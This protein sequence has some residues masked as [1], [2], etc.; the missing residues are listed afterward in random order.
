MALVIRFDLCHRLC[1]GL[2]RFFFG[3]DAL[4]SFLGEYIFCFRF[5]ICKRSPSSPHQTSLD[6]QLS[7][8][9][10]LGAMFLT[11]PSAVAL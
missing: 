5:S 10:V 4:C 1:A 8:L 6:L 2:G 7:R 9:E 11:C 3:A